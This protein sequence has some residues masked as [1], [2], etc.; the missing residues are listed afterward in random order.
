MSGSGVPIGT[1]VIIT[2]TLPRRIPVVLPLAPTAFCGVAAGS[3]VR[4]AA[5]DRIGASTP[6]A[7]GSATT[8]SASFCPLSSDVVA[9]LRHAVDIVWRSHPHTALLLSVGLSRL[10]TSFAPDGANIVR[11]TSDCESKA[12]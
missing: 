12:H 8:V 9:C 2:R 10:A 1:L 6:P 4:G 5:E 3:A 11:T 7:A